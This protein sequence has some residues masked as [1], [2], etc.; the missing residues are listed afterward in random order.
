MLL[1][2]R[3]PHLNC[4]MTK[5]KVQIDAPTQLKK[6]VSGD[7]TVQRGDK[8]EACVALYIQQV[9]DGDSKVKVHRKKKYPQRISDAKPLEI[10]VSIERK[11]FLDRDTEYDKLTINNRMQGS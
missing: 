5:Q 4:Y 3:C 9:Y 1:G 6:K 10:D 2:L 11:E 8:Y 7:T